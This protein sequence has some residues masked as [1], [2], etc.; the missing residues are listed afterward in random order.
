MSFLKR[1]FN[2]STSDPEAGQPGASRRE[3]AFRTPEE[4][5]HF[6]AAELSE[7]PRDWRLSQ[8]LGSRLHWQIEK[9][10]IKPTEWPHQDFWIRVSSDLQFFIIT[11][12]N[13]DI[14]PGGIHQDLQSARVIEAACVKRHGLGKCVRHVIATC[15]P[16]EWGYS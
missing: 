15:K 6:V 1:F 14:G 3:I 13:N 16:N 2:K 12:G 9:I 10:T 8:H 7:L 4:V 11:C 5:E